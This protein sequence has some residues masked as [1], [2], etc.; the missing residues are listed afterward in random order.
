MQSETRKRALLVS[1]DGLGNGG[2]QAVMM[3]VV[4]SLS[5]CC[6]FDALLFTDE[7]RHYEDEFLSFGGKIHRIPKYEGKSLLMRKLDYYIRGR[8][9]YRNVL[10]LLKR[11]GP[12]DVVHCNNNCEGG[13]V[14]K[15]AFKAGIP[16]R[17]M[18][19]HVVLSGGN[20]ASRLLD[21]FRRRMIERYATVRIGCSREACRSLYLDPTD[22]VVIGNAYD[23]KRF[24]R[25]RF[26]ETPNNPLILVQIG[27]FTPL[28]NQI[29]SVEVLD[30][31][32]KLQP[33]AKLKLVGFRIG[34][35]EDEIKKRIVQLGLENKV[36]LLPHDTDTPE[37]LSRAA[38]MLLPSLH[39]G[40]GIVL[41]EAQAMGVRCYA[42]DGVP[43]EANRGG[44]DYLPLSEG[45]GRWAR[46]IA[47][48]YEK[49]HGA[50]ERYDVS[51]L[52]PVAI[53]RRYKTL[54][55]ME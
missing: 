5:Y 20:P 55:G 15:A 25:T 28:K 36:E 46:T 6:D 8:R 48:D 12:Y 23:D 30:E 32:V 24:D 17:I 34:G 50:H 41:A 51:D 22:S 45:P 53:A 10:K 31:L 35:Y 14:L 52:T 13:I 7:V 11:S 37:L 27:A 39:E 1:C 2:V 9:L 18:H 3:S 40:F 33:E 21:A 44:V 42:S 54:Y 47:E 4:R 26:N 19:A 29:F 38:C 49:K 43:E 16:V